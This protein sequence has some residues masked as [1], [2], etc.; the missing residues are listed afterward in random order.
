MAQDV[1]SIHSPL[2]GRDGEAREGE[3]VAGYFNPLAPRGARLGGDASHETERE[4]QSTRPSRGETMPDLFRTCRGRNFNPLAPRGARHLPPAFVEN[5]KRIS[6]HS[7]LAG[8]DLVQYLVGRIVA[9][10]FN[11]L[12]PRGARRP[13]GR[14]LSGAGPFQS[15]RP[16]RGETLPK[17][18]QRISD[19]DFN[20]LAPRGA[21]RF[22]IM[23]EKHYKEF[24]STRP[25]RGETSQDRGWLMR[26]IISI[27]SP[28]AGRDS[29]GP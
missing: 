22:G 9:I 4:F 28:L 2:A 18:W 10:Y 23:A 7:P 6:I 8:R 19:R 27:H 5:L 26:C 29:F 21:R 1:I 3:E 16:S 15:T 25:S 14:R 11:P 24:Q 20:P 13:S 17:R 12:A